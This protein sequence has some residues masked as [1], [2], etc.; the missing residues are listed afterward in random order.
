MT[1]CH[2]FILSLEC[3]RTMPGASKGCMAKRMFITSGTGEKLTGICVYF[4]RLKT[5]I[6]ISI[7]NVSEV[8]K[9]A[10]FLSR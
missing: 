6:N 8:G 5:D 10:A 7:K 4:I 1:H 9:F 3:G 2:D